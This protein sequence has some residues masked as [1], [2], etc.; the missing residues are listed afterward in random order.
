MPN[1]AVTALSLRPHMCPQP[2]PTPLPPSLASGAANG[3]LKTCSCSRMTSSV[4]AELV[5][6]RTTTF[7]TEPASAG[8]RRRRRMEV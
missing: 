5:F 3:T 2:E 8:R 6:C 1:S 4:V 7:S